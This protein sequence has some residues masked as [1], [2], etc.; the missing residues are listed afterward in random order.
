MKT[1]THRSGK[2]CHWSLLARHRSDDKTTWLMHSKNAA[3]HR[4]VAFTTDRGRRRSVVPASTPATPAPPRTL[5]P[6]SAAQQGEKRSLP[7][8]ILR[9]FLFLLYFLRLYNV[10]TVRIWS[11]FF[12]NWGMPRARWFIKCVEMAGRRHFGRCVRS[13]SRVKPWRRVAY[14]S[15]SWLTAPDGGDAR[16]WDDRNLLLFLSIFF[17]FFASLQSSH[18]SSS[19]KVPY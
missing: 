13:E 18:V 1:N 17:L 14:W 7:A 6:K 16:Q 2:R 19:F 12:L 11:G 9:V 3:D 10:F 8:Y 4:S 15:A 5:H